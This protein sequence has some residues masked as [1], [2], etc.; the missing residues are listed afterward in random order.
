MNNEKGGIKT[1]NQFLDKWLEEFGWLQTRGSGDDLL[2][3]CKECTKLKLERKTRSRVGAKISKDRQYIHCTI[4]QNFS[5]LVGIQN[6]I[7]LF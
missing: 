5:S 4:N 6:H 1:Y 2:M 3:I 7:F